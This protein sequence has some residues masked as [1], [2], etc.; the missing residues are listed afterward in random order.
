MSVMEPE[1]NALSLPGNNTSE[2]SA[3]HNEKAKKEAVLV[4]GSLW[5][6]IWIMSWPLLLLM[7]SN[8]VVGIVDVQLAQTFSASAQAAVGLGDQIVFLFVALIL[9]ASVGTN[10]LVSRAFGARDQEEAISTQGQSLIFALLMGGILTIAACLFSG[11]LMGLFT[12]DALTE[13]LA[14]PYL[15]IYALYFLPFSFLCIV[16]AGF[17]ASGDAKVPLLIV[18]IMTF[19]NVA[20]DFWFVY[21][22]WRSLGING[23]ALAGFSA[24]TIGA[25]IAWF[26]LRQSALKDS[27]RRLLPLNYP[28]LLKLIKISVPA[29]LQRITWTMAIFVVFF[30]LKN[31]PSPTAALAAWTIGIRVESFLFMPMFALGQAVSS[32]VGQNL[33]AKED[34][35]AFQAG[36][37]VSWLGFGLMVVCGTLL[38]LYSPTLARLMA[39]DPEAIK[40]CTSYLQI[41]ALAQPLQA[42]SM[43]FN[44]ALQG[45]GDTRVPMWIT[46]F[47]QWLIRLPLSWLL[48]ITFKF[49]PLGVWIAMSL[50]SS[51]SGL[52]NLWRYQ[53]RAWER[54]KL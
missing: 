34:E 27:A 42:M 5:H 18:L 39:S 28:L 25:C 16:N 43:I 15:I 49:G 2:G 4:S 36:W 7:L 17:R 20:L 33:G 48:A 19:I 8:A 38:F 37:N 40:Y 3:E 14:R 35:R 52:L 6:A 26:K 13:K 9:A 1:A 32:V 30:T 50:S 54:L 21:G 11:N 53:S 29:A 41:C 51:M 12:P 45:A 47:T 31:C 22:P 10:A 24:S 23:L 46:I 44:G